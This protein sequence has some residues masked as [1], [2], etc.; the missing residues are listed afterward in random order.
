MGQGAMK[1]NSQLI[2]CTLLKRTFRF[3]AEVVLSNKQKYMIRC[4]NLGQMTT[5]DVLGSRLW[6][7]KAIGHQC[8]D[9][10][11]LVEVDGG[12]LVGINPELV[13]PLIIEGIKMG[14][15]QELQ[16]YNV[17]QSN[18]LIEHNRRMDIVLERDGQQCFVATE[19]IIYCD[20]R[21]DGY[22]PDSPS[23]GTDRIRQLMSL[24]HDGHRVVLFYAVQHM[25]VERIKIADQID[26]DY[27]KVL[28]EAI[29]EGLEVIAY[30]ADITL[31]NIEMAKRLPILYS[32][33]ITS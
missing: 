11:E 33:D 30:K 8:L 28:R 21:G 15:I 17:M 18:I 23:V 10:W 12:H 3:L 16:D 20:S 1:Y 25:G 31:D 32:E 13:K 2:E 6:F 29:S 27:G 9:T 24:K 22:F 5:C 19:L 4:P 7:S 26:P 14:V